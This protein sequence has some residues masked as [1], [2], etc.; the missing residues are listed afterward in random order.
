MNLELRATPIGEPAPVRWE[1]VAAERAR[2]PPADLRPAFENDGDGRLDALLT[3]EALCVTTGQQPGLLLGPLYSLYK[4]LTALALA[5]RLEARLARPVVPVFWVAGDDHDFLESAHTHVLSRSSDVERLALPDRAPDA[6]LTPMYRERLGPEIAAVLEAF[7]AEQ[8]DTEYRAEVEAWLAGAY[9]PEA[10]VA[11]A[12]AQALTGLLGPRGVL[13]F[14]PTH[15]AAKAAMR[16]WL[17]RALDQA[18]ALDR[19]LADRAAELAGRGASTPVHVGDGASLVMLEGREG[20]DRLVLDDGSLHARRSG[21]RYLPEEL[22]G[23]LE[24]EPER[25]SPNV[26]LRPVVEAALLPTVAYVGGP[27]ELAYLPQCAP[28]YDALGVTPQPPV[29]R[30]SGMIIEARVRKVLDKYDIAPDDLHLPEGQL[31]QRLVRGDLPAEAADA[32]ARLRELLDREYG[33]VRDAAIAIDPTMRKPVEST[34]N[35]ALAGVRDVEKRLVSHLKQRNDTLV[36]QLARAR[37][38]LF[39]LGKPQERI[40]GLPP[41]LTRYG[42]GFVDTVLEAVRT[43]ATDLEGPS[44]AP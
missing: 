42:S 22:A 16:P 27:G 38:A 2:V 36:Q 8:P 5:E 34:R 10:T 13:V 25:F 37:A 28:V 30:W 12:F 17:G 32:F 23:V 6:P 21:E 15:P 40:L 20:R 41:F 24:A 3:G 4:G 39:P 19:A 35:A 26:L 7:W 1:D 29:P 44:G 9:R 33:V 14:R 11:D 18:A 43:W 31:E